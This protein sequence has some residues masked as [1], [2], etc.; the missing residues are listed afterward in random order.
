MGGSLNFCF[1]EGRNLHSGPVVVY[2]THGTLPAG[3]ACAKMTSARGMAAPLWWWQ[4]VPKNEFPIIAPMPFKKQ[5]NKKREV[6]T[7]RTL[8]R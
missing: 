1:V 5:A 2:V 3:F 4:C 7:H 6:G 8:Q